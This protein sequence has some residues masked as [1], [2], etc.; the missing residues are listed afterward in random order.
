MIFQNNGHVSIG[1]LQLFYGRSSLSICSSPDTHCLIFTH[2]APSH[3]GPILPCDICMVKWGTQRTQLTQCIPENICVS[4]FSAVFFLFFFILFCF[5]FKIDLLLFCMY[6]C[7]LH[8][9]QCAMCPQCRGSQ[10]MAQD[11]QELALQMV[12]GAM[13][14]VETKL[15]F[16]TRAAQCS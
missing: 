2:S 13:S 10:K 6:E 8:R 3:P 12:W 4:K 11:P 14:V 7:C 1:I 9:W 5:T 16:S 15:K